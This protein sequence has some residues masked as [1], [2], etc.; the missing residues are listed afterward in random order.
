MYQT[1]LVHGG[2]LHPDVKL[3]QG[4]LCLSGLSSQTKYETLQYAKLT[5]TT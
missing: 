2:R 4:Q 1:F 3:H 5:D